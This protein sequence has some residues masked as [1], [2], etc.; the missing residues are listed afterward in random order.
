MTFLVLKKKEFFDE[1]ILDA[2]AGME[3]VKAGALGAFFGGIAGSAFGWWVDMP[4]RQLLRQGASTSGLL[5]AGSA[6]FYGTKVAV[7]QVRHTDDAWNGPAAG[8]VTGILLG[9][10]TGRIS[11]VVAHGA[12]LPI[13]IG[14]TEQIMSNVAKNQHLDSEQRE[15]RSDDFFKWPRRDPFAKRMEKMRKREGETPASA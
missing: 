15:K 1:N 9:L 3:A 13:I 8:L 10:R 14:F 6:V 4:G 5:A 7:A 12:A 2:S 11:R